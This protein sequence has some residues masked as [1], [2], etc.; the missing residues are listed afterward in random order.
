MS[1]KKTRKRDRR[2]P[3]AANQQKAKAEIASELAEPTV[4]EEPG[5][6]GV[7]KRYPV[8]EAVRVLNRIVQREEV[9]GRE[10][11]N[12]QT[13]TWVLEE[14]CI[15]SV[16]LA[17]WAERIGAAAQAELGLLAPGNVFLLAE[18]IADRWEAGTI[19]VLVRELQDRQRYQE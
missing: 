5:E 17:F 14:I 9:L 8:A 15:A 16:D 1:P 18:Q 4:T 3:T 7:A 12:P 2:K 19:Q 13:R 11:T 6:T 10:L